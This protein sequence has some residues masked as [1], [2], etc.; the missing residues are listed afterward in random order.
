MRVHVLLR[1]AVEL[2]VG[3]CVL[4]AT[5]VSGT[6]AVSFTGDKA[7]FLLVVIWQAGVQEALVVAEAFGFAVFPARTKVDPTLRDAD[8]AC[9]TCGT[10]IEV[11]VCAFGFDRLH[12]NVESFGKLI[13]FD[14]HFSVFVT[15][16]VTGFP[17]KIGRPTFVG[18]TDETFFAVVDAFAV[19]V[20]AGELF[21]GDTLATVALFTF[22][23]VFVFG[24]SV[25]DALVFG[26]SFIDG[27]IGF[28]VA[29]DHTFL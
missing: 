25:L 20:L 15:T 1:D 5:D 16:F 11:V 18:R 7:E 21:G 26:A 10:G 13:G 29:F 23:A 28:G 4:F 8:Q 14:A 27:T 19:F 24:A 22:S 17:A 6:I 9:G 2:V 12:T 3:F